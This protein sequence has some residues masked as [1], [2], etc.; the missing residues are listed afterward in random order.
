MLQFYYLHIGYSIFTINEYYCASLSKS[1]ELMKVVMNALKY[2]SIKSV[3]GR[4][5]S[6]AHFNFVEGEVE[7]SCCNTTHKELL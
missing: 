3:G 4:P 2:F 5:C 6:S 7:N 1:I